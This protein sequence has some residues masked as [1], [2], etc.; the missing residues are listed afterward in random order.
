M[1]MDVNERARASV[2]YFRS[3]WVYPTS[4][5]FPVVPEDTWYLTISFLGTVKSLSG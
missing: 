3:P 2:Q 4:V 1:P 5:G